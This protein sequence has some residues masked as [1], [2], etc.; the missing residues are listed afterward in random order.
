MYIKA[1]LQTETPLQQDR[2]LRVSNSRERRVER[3]LSC[4]TGD[5]S[6]F[7]KQKNKKTTTAGTCQ[8]TQRGTAPLA[9]FS[10]ESHAH[11]L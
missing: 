11:T 9:G 2:R 7:L 6:L 5:K 3:A 1:H 4:Q 10:Y 8:H